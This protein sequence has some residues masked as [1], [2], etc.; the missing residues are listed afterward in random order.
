MIEHELLVPKITFNSDQLRT[1]KRRSA[2]CIGNES[3]FIKF[4]NSWYHG[5]RQFLT[6]GHHISL[7]RLTTKPLL[8]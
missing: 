1:W 5:L 6:S 8:G 2:I 4:I 7:F 3:K